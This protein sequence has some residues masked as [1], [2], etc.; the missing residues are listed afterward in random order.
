[1][2][3]KDILRKISWNICNCRFIV[4]W[5]ILS[6]IRRRVLETMAA[7]NVWRPTEPETSLVF[8]TKCPLTIHDEHQFF[9]RI[10]NGH[11]PSFVEVLSIQN[12]SE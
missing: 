2:T 4:T 6:V 1:M 8:V 12:T 3:K 7:R 10:D 5:S 11:A 9:N